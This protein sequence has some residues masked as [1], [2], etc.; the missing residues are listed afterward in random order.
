MPTV[1]ETFEAE[2]DAEKGFDFHRFV[3]LMHEHARARHSG[4]LLPKN[5]L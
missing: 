3:D 5:H 4:I 2:M 1:L